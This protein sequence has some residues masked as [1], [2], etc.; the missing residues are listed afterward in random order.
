MTSALAPTADAD[1]I[2]PGIVLMLGFCVF[3]P[4]LDVAAKLAADTLP[5]GQIATARFLV[6]V[7]L[8]LPLCLVMGLG[9]RLRRELWGIVTAR[10]LLLIV[11]TYLFIGAIAVMPIA[12]ALAIVFVEP[13]I[14]LIF[15][16]IFFDDEV[17]PRRIGASAVGFAGVLLVIQPSFVEF[18]AV[19]LLPLGTAFSFAA[20]M[21]VTRALSRRMHPVAMQYHTAVIASL[22]CVCVLMM[23]NGRGWPT[24]DPA[25]PQGIVWLWLLG[26]GFFAALSH[27]MITYALKF[28]PSATLAPLH[29]L[30]IVMAALLGYL[31]F[32][33]FPDRLTLTGITIIVG[34]G[35][36]VIHRERVN[37]HKPLV[38]QSPPAAAI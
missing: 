26:V 20:Y 24:L 12:D 29:Y 13:F 34:S 23:A 3:G 8:M 14:I 30:E 33:D 28:A 32:S 31:V 4:M 1:R 35:L 36:Y 7:V 17:G 38:T 11:A 37:A 18:G 9:L 15:A 25:M 6:Q 5:V 16:K 19:A 21:L 2:L 22:I 27:L 10:A